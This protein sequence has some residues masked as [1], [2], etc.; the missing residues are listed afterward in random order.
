[1]SFLGTSVFNLLSSCVE[2][3]GITLLK[4]Y[5]L[6]TMGGD[7]GLFGCGGPGYGSCP[8]GQ[9]YPPSGAAYPPQSYPPSGYSAGY[10]P[11]GYSAGYPPSG[12][13]SAGYAAYPQQGG[14]PVTSYPAC[15]SP[16]STGYSH[17]G[18]FGGS[19]GTHHAAPHG[20]YGSHGKNKGGFG[21]GRS[22]GYGGGKLK[23]WK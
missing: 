1:M 3:S 4:L 7:R 8:Q 10:Q 2:F 12:Y 13:S 11:S 14:Y 20:H 22:H 19:Y 9:S 21:H 23:K 16:P 18:G 5:L 15:P 6:T 17:H